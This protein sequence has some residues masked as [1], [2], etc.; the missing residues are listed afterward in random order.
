MV[1][2]TTF[3]TAQ[4]QCACILDTFIFI[5]SLFSFII[6]VPPPP[7]AG[8]ALILALKL[9]EDVHLSESNITENETYY[10]IAEVLKCNT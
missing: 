4:Q 6:Q 5:V 8:A 7:S 3:A 10:W 9:S 2:N 1:K